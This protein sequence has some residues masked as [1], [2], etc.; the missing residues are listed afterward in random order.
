MILHVQ[1][2]LNHNGTYYPKGS[3][4]QSEEGE[5][6]PLIEEGILKVVEGANTIEEAEEITGSTAGKAEE[7]ATEPAV[8]TAQDTWG[9]RPDNAL[10]NQVS[11]SNDTD[12]NKDAENAPVAPVVAKFTVLQEFTI[13]NKDSKNFGKHEVGAVI[14][15]DPVAAQPLVDNGTLTPFVEPAAPTGD[16]L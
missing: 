7:T 9:P 8:P 10:E 16:N 2:N 12:A 13:E 5:F 11:G 6:V 3:F 14:E 4:I 1:T 15:A